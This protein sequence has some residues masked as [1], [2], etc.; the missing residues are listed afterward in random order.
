MVQLAWSVGALDICVANAGSARGIFTRRATQS[1]NPSSPST[2]RRGTV[3]P[4]ATRVMRE[5]GYGRIVLVSSTGDS[6][7]TSA[8][9]LRRH[10]GAMLHLADRWPPK[11][12]DEGADEPAAPYAPHRY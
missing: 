9:R 3:D 10:K 6:T 4:A 2:L 1:S 7:A 12:N 5:A 11:E 8:V